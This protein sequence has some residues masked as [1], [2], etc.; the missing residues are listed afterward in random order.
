ME[1]T[2]RCSV[3]MA[4][5]N[6]E[7]YITK[8][9]ETV[10]H[11]LSENDELII[12]DDGS[13]D[14]T[15]TIVQSFMDVDKR[16]RLIEGPRK[17]VICNFESAL[18]YARGRYIFLCDQDDVWLECKVEKVLSAM[19]D[20][21]TLV[22]H[23]AEVIQNGRILYP[24]FMQ[25]RGSKLGFINNI[26]KNS[27]LGCCMAFKREMLEYILPFP[28]RICMHD[29]WIGLVNELHGKSVMLPEVLFQY[30][31]HDNNVSPMTKQK[32][33]KQVQDRVFM[34]GSILQMQWRVW[35]AK[36]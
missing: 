30:R 7:Q 15:R 4:S 13:K 6:G 18:K 28:K 21:V 23:D 19:A 27:Y 29:Q 25:H 26:I 35:K 12:S 10:L 36:K 8:Q 2:I 31:R 3:V 24:S 20:D 22:L 5:Y 34:I 16:I 11:N 14:A 9:I 1:N 32:F 17:G 33:S